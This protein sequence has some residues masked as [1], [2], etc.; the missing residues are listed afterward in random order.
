MDNTENE[1]QLIK[2]NPINLGRILT[3]WAKHEDKDS[4]PLRIDLLD[5][6]KSE[7][8][9]NEFNDMEEEK[10]QEDCKEELPRI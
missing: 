9:G 8:I 4:K 7:I 6:S 1:I 2:T 3:I 5:S 10:E